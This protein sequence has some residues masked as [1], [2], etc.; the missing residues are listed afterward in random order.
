VAFPVVLAPTVE[1]QEFANAVPEI[2]QPRLP[3]GAAAPIT[4]VTTVVKVRVPPNVGTPDAD[5]VIV[6]GVEPTTVEFEDA[7]APSGL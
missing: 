6:G 2:F 3:P 5:M 7:T 1:I 4:P